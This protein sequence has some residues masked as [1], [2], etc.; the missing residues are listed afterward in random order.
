MFSAKMQRRVC[1]RAF[2]TSVGLLS[3]LAL[4]H[5]A[6]AKP[7][8]AQGGIDGLTVPPGPQGTNNFAVERPN[9]AVPRNPVTIPFWVSPYQS[10][11]Q[12]YDALMVGTDPALGSATTTVPV[13][14]VPLRMVFARHGAVL[15]FPGMGEEL[16]GSPFFTSVP[17]VVGTTQ[18]LDAYRRADFWTQVA[19]TSPD[20]HT[21]LGTPTILST[22]TLHVPPALG[23]SFVDASTNRRFAYVDGTWLSGQLR[24]LIASLHVDP[25]ALAVFLA[26]NTN[27][28][29]S[30]VDACPGPTCFA[31]G[32]YHGAHING[33][34]NFQGT[35]P[36]QSVNTYAYAE[37]LDLGDAVP[38]GI[39]VHLLP[40]SHELLE[41][42]DDPIV[43]AAQPN[44]QNPFFPVGFAGIAPLWTS[45]F[46][47]LGCANVY[48]VADPLED[49]APGVGV[50]DS[51]HIDV[52]ADAVFQSWFA[53]QSPSTAFGGLY[54]LIGVFQ[55]FSDSCS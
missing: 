26:P 15:D 32:G 37:F 7:P 13:V 4:A 10:G 55:G 48:E 21:L 45:P 25:R 46:Y 14:I 49:G 2:A 5:A 33:N 50:P 34:P 8:F 40:V 51:G 43:F 47:S 23:H 3:V 1:V 27:G 36:P 9:A 17:Y 31:F 39:N 28:T 24:Q 53:R 6:N 52:F 38:N 41:W 44:Q 42:L 30:S 16:A 12:A 35:Q 54:D 19:T 20:Y 18:Y 29:I 22:Q 11:G